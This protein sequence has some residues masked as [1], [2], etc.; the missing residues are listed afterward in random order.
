MAGAVKNAKNKIE[1]NKKDVSTDSNWQKPTLKSINK[2]PSVEYEDRYNMSDNDTMYD[3]KFKQLVNEEDRIV[4][5]NRLIRQ[6][7]EENSG[8]S[9]NPR[10]PYY[11]KSKNLESKLES[12]NQRSKNIHNQQ[13]ELQDQKDIYE[14]FT[15]A[16]YKNAMK[17]DG[18][19]DLLNPLQ[20]TP[21]P[22]E[23]PWYKKIFDGKKQTPGGLDP[24]NL[25][26]PS[27]DVRTGVNVDLQQPNAGGVAP[28]ELV[29]LENTL[30]SDQKN[31][32][33]SYGEFEDE[34]SKNSKEEASKFTKVPIGSNITVQKQDE[35]EQETQPVEYRNF[36]QR[37]I[38]QDYD[39]VAYNFTLSMLSERDTLSAQEHIL[40]TSYEGPGFSAWTPQDSK[41]IIAETGS[42]VLSIVDVQIN[43]TAGPINNGK[44][45]TGAVDFSINVVQ[46]LS[47]SFTDILVN[48]AVSL[49]IPDGLKATYLLE[50]KFTGRDPLDGTIVNPIPTTSRQFLIEII[51]VEASVNTNGASYTIRA[52]RAGDK[53]LREK[54]YK[55]D[56]PLQLTN[57]RTVRDLVSS[58]AE[59]IN[60]NELDKLA[61]EKGILDEY[62]IT[63][64][65]WSRQEIGDDA[66][67]DTDT[68]ENVTTNL[69]DSVQFDKD[70]MMFRIPQGTSIDR[71]LEFGLSH[72]KKLQKLAKGM[73]VGASTDADSSNSDDVTNF[74]KHIFHIKVDVKNIAWDILR[75]EYAKE[76]HYTISLF[77]TI[78]PE[79][80]PGVWGKME[81]VEKEKINALINKDLG[82][83]KSRPYKAL[84]KRY[85]YLFTGL[86]DKIL[87]F[88]IK[89]NNQFFFALHSYRG[90]YS[91]VSEDTKKFISKSAQTLADF[92]QQQSAVRDAWKNYLK[93][94][95]SN[96]ELPADQQNL[97]AELDNSTS[98]TEFQNQRQKLIDLYVTG[99]NDGTFEGDASLAQSLQD[100]DTV[101]EKRNLSTQS[102]LSNEIL[103]TSDKSITNLDIKEYA[104]TIDRNSVVESIDS[105]K[106]PFQIMWGA[107]PD[108]YRN[109]FNA[110]GESPGKG[111]FDSV[112]ESS[113][114]DF[115]ADLVAMDMD[116]KGDPF[117][118]ESERDPD[119][120]RSAS[121]HEGE[122]YLLFRAITSAGEPDPNTGLANPNQEGKE[123]MLN[124]IYAVVQIMNSFTGGQFIQN[125]KGVKEAFITD[126]SI[127]E[128]YKEEDP[129]TDIVL[130]QE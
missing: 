5:E 122:N 3:W 36:Y 32:F 9:V 119:F 30:T 19:G 66:L 55:T 37:N 74:V 105:S 129:R 20:E 11:L 14:N 42:T 45:L 57:L 100:A 81:E 79:I 22:D 16:Q 103:Q 65:P 56:R 78:R 82:Q 47:A 34:V 31:A 99:V 110:E 106:K 91:K 77:P 39:S 17:T 86:N 62:Y 93:N 4:K 59:T 18:Q 120:V 58:V 6:E 2:I 73:D 38:L 96:L 13:L 54:T 72:S 128:Q 60:L 104:E 75:N 85:D 112:I 94:K 24:N 63:L 84:L 8:R 70:N 33:G 10:S 109:K 111:H 67:I 49:G 41:V 124:G 125:I 88:D 102:T 71:V 61:I 126:I 76:Y 64:D 15:M 101:T 95:S 50:L 35:E 40:Q 107:V 26:N 108:D 127:L 68:L 130:D 21:N 12:N 117:W 97:A 98:Y 44:R 115:E 43:A 123:Q 23:K 46:P 25:A 83:S 118:L 80:A 92:K 113:L 87:R 114:A 52:A 89:Y 48:S 53:G 121:Y 28:Q 90:I 7:L 1:K 69:S 29:S 27:D 51:A 116:I